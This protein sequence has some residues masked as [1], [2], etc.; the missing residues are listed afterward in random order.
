[1][2]QVSGLERASNHYCRHVRRQSLL[3]HSSL[4]WVLL[5][6]PDL[7]AQEHSPDGD[8]ECHG[9][10]SPSLSL[11]SPRSNRDHKHRT[12]S[13]RHH[14]RRRLCHHLLFLRLRSLTDRRT[15]L[16]S[17]NLQEDLLQGPLYLPTCMTMVLLIVHNLHHLHHIWV[18]M[19]TFMERVGTD[20]D[21]LVEAMEV[22]P[23]LADLVMVLPLLRFS[24]N[25]HR[26]AL[27][28]CPCLLD[29]SVWI[30]PRSSIPFLPSSGKTDW[31]NL[32][33][34]INNENSCGICEG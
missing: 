11:N 23:D 1:M 3:R 26:R 2:F 29:L 13:S 5:V 6:P 21:R 27:N 22:M 18:A 34:W 17:D 32:P 10:L 30:C 9:S 24:L 12:S 20:G 33:P 7:V 4:T 31:L 16:Q 14:R 8:L 28:I 15:S 25:S 19:T